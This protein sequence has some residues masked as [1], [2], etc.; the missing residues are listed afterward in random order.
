MVKLKS[1]SK[2]SKKRK[3]QSKE[4][5]APILSR[6]EQLAQKR[7]ARQQLQAAITFITLTVLASAFIGVILSFATEPKLGILAGAAIACLVI[8]YKYPRKALWAFLIYLPFSGTVIYTI[9]G[10]NASPVLQLAKDAFYIP[11]L[12]ALLLECQRKN[13]PIM[14]SNGLKPSVVILFLLCLITLLFVNGSQQLETGDVEKP[15]AMGILGFKVFVGYIPLIFC[16]YYLIRTKKELLFTAR[17]HLVLVLICCALGFVQY[18]FLKTGRCQGTDH[19]SGDQLFKA[20]LD[21]KCLVGGALLYSPS[22]GVIRLPGTFVAPWQ[23]SWFLIGNAFLTFATAF[24]DPSP[25]WRIGGMVGMAAVFVN[26][27][28]CGQ[29]IAL[30]LVPAVIAILLLL[31][32]Q[33][34]NLKRFIPIGVGLGLVLTIAAAQNPQVVQERIDSFIGRWNAS[35]PYAFIQE[36]FDWAIGNEPGLLGKGLGRATNSARSFGKIQLVE[37]YYPKVLYEVG[38]LGTIAFLAVVTS[39]TV[40]TFK[41]YRSIRE[42]NLRSFGASFW[43]FILIISYNTYYYPLDVDPVAVY[44]WFFAGVALKLPEL[45]KQEQEKL[46]LAQFENFKPK[47][48]RKLKGS[49]TKAV[50]ITS[51]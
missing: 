26:A 32:G 4:S 46:K 6:K 27:V 22:Q 34:T 10:A 28:I 29:R 48:Q 2:K 49:K 47:K 38:Y 19:L 30:A 24:S 40:I 13:L 15:L 16:A 14:I 42:P 18:M 51:H 33:V 12:I 37:T 11:A 36:Q 23:W 20:T 25:V 31:T 7:K 5:D 1:Q 50:A 44:Y 43:V 9:G 41:S 35:P 8:C 39:L 3:Q 17:L 45:D 21:A